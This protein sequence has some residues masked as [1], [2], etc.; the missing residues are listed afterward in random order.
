MLNYSD[1]SIM[2]KTLNCSH[3]SAVPRRTLNRS[4]EEEDACV[5]GRTLKGINHRE[6]PAMVASTSARAG[7]HVPK[8]SRQGAMKSAKEP[9]AGEAREWLAKH[10]FLDPPAG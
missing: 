7:A 3:V 10:D 8:S 2:N 6:L 5:L 4:E 9:T 1:A